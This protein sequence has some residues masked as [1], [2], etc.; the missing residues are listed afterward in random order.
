VLTAALV[1]EQRGEDGRILALQTTANAR[2]A[3]GLPEL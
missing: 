1:A 3:F 2:R